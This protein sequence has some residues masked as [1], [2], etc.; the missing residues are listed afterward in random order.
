MELSYL[1]G[2]HEN[3]EFWWGSGEDIAQP[4]IFEMRSF[5]AR[6]ANGLAHITVSVRTEPRTLLAS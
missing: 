3:T 2:L 6:K 5:E 4:L 1:D